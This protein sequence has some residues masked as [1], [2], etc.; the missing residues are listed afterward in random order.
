MKLYYDNTTPLIV[1]VMQGVAVTYSLNGEEVIKVSDL[2]SENRLYFSTT[3]V[4]QNGV[5]ICNVAE[6]EDRVYDW[7]RVDNLLIQKLGEKN[8]EFGITDDGYSCYIEFPEDAEE[9]IKDG[10][11]IVYLRTSGNV[12]NVAINTI[13]KFYTDTYLTDSIGNSI[14]LSASNV[15]I[16]NTSPAIGGADP[17]TVNE[18]YKSY[19]KIV[20]TFDTLITI[21]DYINAI[22]TSGL[23]S[24]GFVCDKTN[25][26]QCTYT[27]KAIING[28]DTDRVYIET[29]SETNTKEI[30][31][32]N[33][34]LYL[35]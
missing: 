30:G 5:F 19:K 10:I 33:I 15:T 14:T 25:D 12:G 35:L 16:T 31:S 6:E 27:V 32:L 28:I 2:D 3:D 13:D 11:R 23:V 24:N 17:E 22:L 29:N 18:A 21:R 1:K 26:I 34:K 8:F 4:A 9:Q 7:K 20:G